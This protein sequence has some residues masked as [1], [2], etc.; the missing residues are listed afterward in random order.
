MVV[1]SELLAYR[2]QHGATLGLWGVGGFESGE[3]YPLTLVYYYA[4][5][6]VDAPYGGTPSVPCSEWFPQPHMWR[7]LPPSW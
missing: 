4:K 3:G 2:R 6:V 1:A 5:D 7:A